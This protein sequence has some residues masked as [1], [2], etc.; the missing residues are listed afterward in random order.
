MG[1]FFAILDKISIFNFTFSFF[2]TNFAAKL[3]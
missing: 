3:E 1:T 2:F